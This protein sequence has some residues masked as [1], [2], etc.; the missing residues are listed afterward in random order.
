MRAQFEY[1]GQD[2]ERPRIALLA[3]DP[4]VLV[5]DLAATFADLLYE[6]GDGVQDVEGLE[7][8]R[9]QGQAILRRNEAVRPLAHDRRHVPRSEESVEA[10]VG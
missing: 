2:G 4:G 7:A 5:L 1:L 8:R 9:Y 10:Q 6:H 3:H